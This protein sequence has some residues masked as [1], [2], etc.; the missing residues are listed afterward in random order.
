MNHDDLMCLIDEPEVRSDISV[1]EATEAFLARIDEQKSLNIFFTVTPQMALEDAARAD[2]ARSE[3]RRLP[4]D[5][6]PFAIKDNVN[7]AG[8]RTTVASKIFENWVAEHD[9]EVVSR[10]RRA[11]AIVL[12]KAALH[13]FVYGVTCINP[14]FGDTRNPWDPERVPGGSSGGSGAAVAAD[15]CVAAIGSD[16]GGSI[17]IPAA[18][19]GVVGIR[20]TVGL[21][22]NRGVYPVSWA[23]DTVGPLARSV[24][25]VAKV[26]GVIAGFDPLDFT[27]REAQSDITA[28]TRNLKGVRI[29]VVTGELVES[30]E[31]DILAH[32]RS[33]SEVLS[34]LGAD[35][36]SI[37]IAGIAWSIE[38]CGVKIR[39]DAWALHKQH[40]E[41]QPDLISP[42]TLRRLKS[43]AEV[44]GAD[45]SINE[46]RLA[47]WRHELRE[48]LAKVDA[49]LTP[50]TR[51]AAPR[52]DTT[53]VME[54]TAQ[55]THLTYPWSAAQAPAISLPCGLNDVGLPCGIQ[56]A[57]ASWQEALL[58]R[59]A[60]AFQSVTD[61]HRARPQGTERHLGAERT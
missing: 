8:V 2:R 53:E 37:E 6:M 15:L 34:Y 49:V 31:A 61:W 19:N 43:A 9:S 23:L 56:V 41:E 36:R 51:T 1:R 46:R 40:V 12:G 20:P 10:L 25:D 13:E 42:D 44:T 11:G 5:G 35:V 3:G 30:A 14:F 55:L 27:S 4:L 58:L 33:A 22:S 16:T 26:L 7:V 24:T 59:I 38:A 29:G 60:A 32:T 18:L 17:R 28:T 45:Y 39:T 47:E 21:V 48:V 52:F 50:T 54:T 57:A